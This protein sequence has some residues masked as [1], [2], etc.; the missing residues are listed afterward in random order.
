MSSPWTLREHERQRSHDRRIRIASSKSFLHRSHRAER[1][2]PRRRPY[3]VGHGHG[4][5]A[6][7]CLRAPAAPMV[8]GVSI[9]LPASSPSSGD[10]A[11]RMTLLIAEPWNECKQPTPDVIANDEC[12]SHNGMDGIHEIHTEAVWNLVQV[13]MTEETM[14]HDQRFQKHEHLR[15]HAEFARVYDVRCSAGDHLL[16]LYVAENELEWSRLGLSVGKRVGN[17]V[18]R[19]YVRRRIRE[20]FRTNKHNLPRGF[21]VIC[22]ARPA[23]GTHRAQVAESFRALFPAAVRRYENRMRSKR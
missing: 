5:P 19:N 18:I 10:P 8:M 6:D 11:V 13:G 22:V 14:P 23:A 15:K 12:D 9:E 4:P 20:E 16:V 1:A 21:D 3:R 7:A 2:S 17:S